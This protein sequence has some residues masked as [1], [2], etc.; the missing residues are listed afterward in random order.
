M[1]DIERKAREVAQQLD[2][3]A[4]RAWPTKGFEAMC[5]TFHVSKAE[6]IIAA[7]IQSAVAETYEE[8]VNIAEKIVAENWSPPGAAKYLAAALRARFPKLSS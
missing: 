7:A 6:E 5:S 3:E 1:T 4:Y 2:A 8:C